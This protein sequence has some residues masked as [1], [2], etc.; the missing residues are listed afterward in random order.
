MHSVPLMP[1]LLRGFGHV[2]VVGVE[3]EEDALGFGV[4]RR[5]PHLVLEHVLEGEHA[6]QLPAPRGLRH[7]QRV[8]TR[9]QRQRQVVTQVGVAAVRPD[10]LGP[11]EHLVVHA[12]DAARRRGLRPQQALCHGR[13]GDEAA[14]RERVRRALLQPVGALPGGGSARACT[15]AWRSGVG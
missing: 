14:G 12:A 7:L 15:R 2:R 13:P 1:S 5:R 3:Y 8:V 11:A 6:A 4:L 10:P 9:W